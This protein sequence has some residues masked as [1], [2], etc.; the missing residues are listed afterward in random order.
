[1]FNLGEFD[2]LTGTVSGGGNPAGTGIVLYQDN[3]AM[4]SGIADA[5]GSFSIPDVIPGDYLGVAGLNLLYC[6]VVQFTVTEDNQTRDFVLDEYPGQLNF[7]YAGF[8]SEMFSF[9]PNNTF[10]FG[11]KITE[12]EAARMAGHVLAGVCFK[13]PTSSTDATISAGVWRNNE[14]TQLIPINGFAADEWVSVSLEQYIVVDSTDDLIIGYE[15]T[16]SDGNL[17]WMDNGPNVTGKGAWLRTQVWSP[18]NAAYNKNACIEALFI[19]QEHATVSGQVILDDGNSAENA[20]VLTNDWFTARTEVNGDYTIDLMPGTY[21]L[22]A[23]KPGYIE[24]PPQV[25]TVIAG[26]I[27][28]GIDIQ[29]ELVPTSTDDKDSSPVYADRITAYPNPFNPETTVSYSL[30]SAGSV[31]LTVYNLKGQEV[32]RLFSGNADK[33]TFS[34]QWSGVDNNGKAVSSGVYFC[35]MKTSKGS[36]SCKLLL[37]K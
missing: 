33:G 18:F 35:T 3:V 11:I 12:T 8:P 36:T 7:S 37:L 31:E 21:Q 2:Q 4:Y 6:D 24:T 25:V 16:S 9:V 20:L 10:A 14:L 26:E 5:S 34:V 19:E 28:N 22:T 27:L 13:T 29:L 17:L 1:Q 30:S 15:I 23:S 32:K